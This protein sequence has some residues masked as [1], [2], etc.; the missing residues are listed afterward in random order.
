M[1]WMLRTLE[2]ELELVRALRVSASKPQSHQHDKH[3]SSR[4][5]QQNVPFTMVSNHTNG[6]RQSA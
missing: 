6:L 4:G 3:Q 1:Y 2:L 5:H